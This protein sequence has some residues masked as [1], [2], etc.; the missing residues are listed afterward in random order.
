MQSLIYDFETLGTNPNDSAV[1]SMAIMEF[2]SDK[3]LAPGYTYSQLLQKC[4]TIKFDVENQVRQYGRM[5]D[6]STLA[7]WGEQSMEAQAQLAPSSAD[8][9]I[10]DLYDWLHS[11]VLVDGIERVYTRG[12][13]FDP[14]FFQSLLSDGSKQDPFPFYILRDTRSTIEG[15]TLFNKEIKN[16]F[17]V[18]GLEDQ[19]IA[20]DPSHDI[21][22]DV[23]RMQFLMQ[24]VSG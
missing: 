16:S 24:Q 1:I 23:A 19:F 3:F 22:M 4:K 7:W 8:V 12:N 6:Q 18:P 13:T 21:A 17:I 11:E 5:I 2:N 10:T 9:K 14:L 15:M 20:H